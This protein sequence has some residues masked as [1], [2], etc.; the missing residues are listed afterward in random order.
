VGTG[1]ARDQTLFSL[2]AFLVPVVVR[3]IVCKVLWSALRLLIVGGLVA[4]FF[5]SIACVISLMNTDE[6]RNKFD[7]MTTHAI[8]KF[9]TLP[10]PV[11][12]IPSSAT[13][14]SGPCPTV[15]PAVLS[16][17][18]VTV[19]GHGIERVDTNVLEG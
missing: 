7:S 1:F 15:A 5:V 13:S 4:G 16:F 18:P 3:M 12:I 19:I 9:P 10:I 6:K 14:V 11:V 17:I 2:K 8:V